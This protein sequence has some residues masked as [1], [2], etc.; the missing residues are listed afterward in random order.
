MSLV[1]DFDDCVMMALFHLI[2]TYSLT[3][4]PVFGISIA[5]SMFFCEYFE[6]FNDDKK[7]KRID[8]CYWSID[9]W[10]SRMSLDFRVSDLRFDIKL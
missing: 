8:V 3:C 10:H 7:G 5:L 1:D 2:V 6:L 4:Q 9:L